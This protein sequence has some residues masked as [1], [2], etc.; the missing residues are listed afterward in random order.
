MRSPMRALA[1]ALLL[2]A[3]LAMTQTITV[4]GGDFTAPYYTFD[5]G[6]PPTLV[7]GTTYEFVSGS[8]SV[9]GDGAHPFR[10]TGVDGGLPI[11]ITVEAGVAPEY[12]CAKHTSMKATFTISDA[13]P[14]AAPAPCANMGQ[15][16]TR[17]K[18]DSNR[19]DSHNDSGAAECQSK[20]VERQDGTWSPCEYRAGGACFGSDQP[21][22]RYGCP[23]PPA[24]PKRRRR[25][26]AVRLMSGLEFIG[27][28]SINDDDP[29]KCVETF[30]V[31]SA[32][33]LT[34]DSRSTGT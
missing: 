12:Y 16:A 33:F 17:T 1:L 23:P 11:T 32:E 2:P 10:I 27:A 8:S 18:A 28:C 14:P 34:D 4:S 19:C 13:P 5:G 25:R 9:V 20:R 6:A 24:P 7:V 30:I 15:W 22:N 21:E 26:G 31:R 3:T 29:A